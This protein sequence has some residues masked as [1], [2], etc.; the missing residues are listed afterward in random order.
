[1]NKMRNKKV[2]MFEKVTCLGLLACP[3]STGET[4]SRL[5]RDPRILQIEHSKNEA[6]YG[7][8]I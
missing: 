7:K 6:N 3:P 4:S 8:N 2:V 5:C 1:M